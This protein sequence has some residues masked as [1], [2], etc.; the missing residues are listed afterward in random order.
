MLFGAIKAKVSSKTSAGHKQNNYYYSMLWSPL[1][2]CIQPNMKAKMLAMLGAQSVK[3]LNYSVQ[4]IKTNWK[5]NIQSKVNLFVK[6][7]S[8]W[9]AQNSEWQNG[10][11]GQNQAKHP[12]KM[13]IRYGRKIPIDFST[14]A[15]EFTRTSQNYFIFSQSRAEPGETEEQQ[16]NN[17]TT[18][19]PGNVWAMSH[20][21]LA[22]R[23][24]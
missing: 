23:K 20:D 2:F 14:L 9:P 7:V 12:A 8:N 10:R 17:S 19:R 6:Y 18:F 11:N 3:C 4:K 22:A 5:L 13:P 24:Q 21:V 15:E 16:R 1:K